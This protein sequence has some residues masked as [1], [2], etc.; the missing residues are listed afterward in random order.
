M[1]IIVTG[2][3]RGIGA[4]ILATLR[5]GGHAVIG[6]ATATGNGA[7]IAADFADPA[8]PARCGMPRSPA[9]AARSTS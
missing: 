5:D 8:A 1:T 4:S 2:S 7:D 3:S 9:R 6:Q